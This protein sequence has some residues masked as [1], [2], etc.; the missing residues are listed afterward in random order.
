M[1]GVRWTRTKKRTGGLLMLTTHNGMNATL[2]PDRIQ[3]AQAHQL[4]VAGEH[5]IRYYQME[6]D[7]LWARI[8]EL[9]AEVARLKGGCEP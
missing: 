1:L 3:S 6:N 4:R 2:N 5:T 8:R 7:R 9:E